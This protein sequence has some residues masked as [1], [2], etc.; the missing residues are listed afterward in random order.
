MI[1]P[2]ALQNLVVR[3]SRDPR[4]TSVPL[5]RSRWPH[6]SRKALVGLAILLEL[7]VVA[8]LVGTTWSSR[9]ITVETGSYTRQGPLPPPAP[10]AGR[11]AWQRYEQSQITAG[12]ATVSAS[13]S[14]QVNGQ[15][16]AAMTPAATTTIAVPVP[17]PAPTPT[18]SVRAVSIS[19]R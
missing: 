14:A 11:A 7:V 6:I 13:Q 10:N 17:V 4:P 19:T 1:T 9:G 18:R 12:T 2:H 16:N 5:P 8:A 15:A 3:E